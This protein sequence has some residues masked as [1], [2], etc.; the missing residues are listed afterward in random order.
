VTTEP[1]ITT[2]DLG[3]AEVSEATP[4]LRW[5]PRSMFQAA[6]LRLQQAWRVGSVSV[7]QIR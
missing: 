3:S 2:L 5:V 6:D 1:Q 7:S 4:E